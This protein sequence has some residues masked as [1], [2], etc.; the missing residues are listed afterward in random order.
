[1]LKSCEAYYSEIFEDLCNSEVATVRNFNKSD[2]DDL[3]IEEI[4]TRIW[5]TLL[6]SNDQT[7]LDPKHG[8]PE[9]HIEQWLREN[10]DSVESRTL[11]WLDR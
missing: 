6:A 8:D 9:S 5:G 4:H 1:M 7:I 10:P 11:L 2:V 3:I